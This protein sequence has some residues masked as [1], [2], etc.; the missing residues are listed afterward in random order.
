MFSIS[1]AD[2]KITEEI[3]KVSNLLEK[4]SVNKCK[5][6]TRTFEKTRAGFALRNV[7]GRAT[8]EAMEKTELDE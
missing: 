7:H 3:L 8:T 6:P 4:Q 5:D 2:Q 1:S